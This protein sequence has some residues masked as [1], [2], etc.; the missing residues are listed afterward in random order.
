MIVTFEYDL[1]RVK[2]NQHA[3]YL[4]QR[5]FSSKVD[6]YSRTDVH[7]GPTALPGPLNCSVINDYYM[8]ADC[9][10]IVS[11]LFIIYTTLFHHHNMVA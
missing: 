7:A 10:R 1:D 8:S 5:S 6:V 9:L 4:G 3:K 11:N 2:V